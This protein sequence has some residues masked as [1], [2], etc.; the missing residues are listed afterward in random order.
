MTRSGRSLWTWTL[1]ARRVAGHEH[2]LAD[3]FEVVADGV[4]V[5]R[6]PEPFGWSRNIVS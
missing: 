2:R 6:P 5:E 1:S 4:D 3:R